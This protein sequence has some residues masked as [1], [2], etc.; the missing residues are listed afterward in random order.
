MK[1]KQKSCIK[2]FVYLQSLSEHETP[3]ANLAFEIHSLAIGDSRMFL[4]SRILL[5]SE[6]VVE[7]VECIFIYLQQMLIWKEFVTHHTLQASGS[8]VLFGH[9]NLYKREE[10]SSRSRC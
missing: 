4:S 1:I 2:S 9:V 6:L 10:Y 8:L 7:Q 5:T 3:L